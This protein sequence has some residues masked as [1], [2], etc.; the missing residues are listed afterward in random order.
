MITFKNLTFIFL[1]LSLLGLVSCQKEEDSINEG[2]VEFS[3]SSN[4][5]GQPS[6]FNF[7]K[8]EAVTLTSQDNLEWDFGLTLITFIT[9]SGESGPGNGGA[10]ILDGTFDSVTDAPE[11]GYR[12]DMAGNLAVTNDWY[13]YNAA[14][15]QFSPIAGKIIVFKTAKGKYA[16]VEIIKADPT[17]DEGN[18]VTPPVIPTQIKYTF[19]YAF[20]SNGSR[21]FN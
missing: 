15:R 19:R 9:N 13:S 16:K 18:I 21:S 17:D 20:Q 8:G 10:L 4:A 6:Y 5:M 11:S 1:A 7:E 2:T 3:V 14:T 12:T